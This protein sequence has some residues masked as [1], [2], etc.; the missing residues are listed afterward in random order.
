MPHIPYL[1]AMRDKVD[2]TSPLDV[3]LA[4]SEPGELHLISRLVISNLTSD[5]TSLQLMV[6]TPGNEHEIYFVGN[7]QIGERAVYDSAKIPVPPGM[8]LIARLVGL[9]NGDILTISGIGILM[10]VGEVT[11]AV[12]IIKGN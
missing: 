7:P 5:Y 4:I 12:V 2:G 10:A 1:I 8:R 6:G 3:E 11:E 9:T